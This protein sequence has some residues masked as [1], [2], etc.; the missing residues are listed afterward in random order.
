[1]GWDLTE[2]RVGYRCFSN[3]G[4]RYSKLIGRILRLPMSADLVSADGNNAD[5]RCLL[6]GEDGLPERQP[7]CF[8]KR[9]VALQNEDLLSK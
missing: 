1:M 3:C 2:Q 5:L 7:E 6:T 4:Y 9:D 8:T